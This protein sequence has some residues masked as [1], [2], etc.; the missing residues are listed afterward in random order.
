MIENTYLKYALF[1]LTLGFF[2]VPLLRCMGRSGFWSLN[3][4]VGLVL[5]VAYT[6]YWAENPDD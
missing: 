6:V 4:Y 1:N 2:E 3:L 5:C